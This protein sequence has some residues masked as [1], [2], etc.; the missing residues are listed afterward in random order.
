M[1]GRDPYSTSKAY[2]EM[3]ATAYKEGKLTL[4]CNPNSTQ[5]W[6]HVHEPL[7]GY[8]MLLDF[9]LSRRCAYAGDRN[10]GPHQRGAKVVSRVADKLSRHWKN[11]TAWKPL[12]GERPHGAIDLKL[13]IF[14]FQNQ[15]GGSPALTIEDSV[16]LTAE[17]TLQLLAG[18]RSRG[19]FRTNSLLLKKA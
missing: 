1:C 18:E 9:L 19:Y 4:I 13:N 6:Q 8:S 10:F 15:L 3:S 11:F 12:R 16:K 2:T 5:L 7:N 14:K 17:W